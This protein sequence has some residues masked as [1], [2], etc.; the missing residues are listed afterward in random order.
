LISLL[1]HNLFGGEILKTHNRKGWHFYN[2]INGE[3]IDFMQPVMEKSNHKNRMEDLPSD[4]D[5]T[6]NYFEPED[7]STLFMR[8]IWS[9]EEAVGLDKS[10]FGLMA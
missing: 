1:I 5:E 7:Y 6:C 9:F 2:R 10:K 8:F 4:P 3:R